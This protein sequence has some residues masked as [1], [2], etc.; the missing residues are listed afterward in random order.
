MIRSEQLSK[1]YERKGRIVPV[2]KN[3]NMSVN[4]GETVAIIGPSGAGKSTLLHQLGLLE[5]PSSGKIYF[6]ER[7]TSVLTDRERTKLRLNG[8][9]FV[10]QFHH[11]LP[12]F[13]A[14]ENIILP[15]LI[16]GISKS[17]CEERGKELLDS[18]NLLDRASHKPGELSGGEQQRVTLARA[19]MNKPRLILADEPTGNLDREA[20]ILLQRLLWGLCDSQNSALLIVTHNQSIAKEADR[21]L[22]MIDGS[23]NSVNL[24]A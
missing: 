23:L 13:S 14:L 15:G 3:V 9:G 1:S 11:L 24:N 18:V 19:L 4:A 21:T 5:N 2:L 20:S 8:I 7:D 6:D 10:F 17:E 12:E 22:E 16:S